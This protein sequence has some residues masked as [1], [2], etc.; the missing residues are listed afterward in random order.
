M[1]IRLIFDPNDLVALPYHHRVPLSYL[2]DY[3]LHL[4]ADSRLLAAELILIRGHDHI[5]LTLD[6]PLIVLLFY[7][8]ETTLSAV[9]LAVG[10][11]A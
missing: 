9:S 1:L 5:F 3:R 10:A 11:F 7:L 4:S 2:S 6:D 8:R